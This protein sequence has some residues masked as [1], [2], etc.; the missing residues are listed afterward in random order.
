MRSTLSI[1]SAVGILFVAPEKLN[2]SFQL[3]GLFVNAAG[4]EKVILKIVEIRPDT[5][6]NFIFSSESASEDREKFKAGITSILSL[7]QQRAM[8]GGTAPSSSGAAP[9]PG[10]GSPVISDTSAPGTPKT[11][12]QARFGARR[13]LGTGPSQELK[14]R[15][16]LLKQNKELAG[17]HRDLVMGKH[18]SEEE[19][20]E[21]RKHLIENKSAMD[22]QQ[23]G[24]SSAWLDL[25]PETGESN[26]VKYVMTPQVIHS[27][28]QQYPSSKLYLFGSCRNRAD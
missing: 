21:N 2:S 18:V 27:V 22:H 15:L 16:A 25:K 4:S 7:R 9:S 28:C 13:G 5:N 1:C 17:L 23:K 6:H 26:D 3:V 14:T 8:N 11:Q 24:Q 10:G 19:F 12:A 20:W